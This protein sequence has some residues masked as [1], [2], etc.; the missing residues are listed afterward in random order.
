MSVYHY[1][2]LEHKA[3]CIAQYTTYLLESGRKYVGA[4]P[5]IFFNNKNMLKHGT[6]KNLKLK[7]TL[8]L[9]SLLSLAA[10]S[11]DAIFFCFPI[12][13]RCFITLTHILLYTNIF[14][15][16]KL[17]TKWSKVILDFSRLPAVAT[18]VKISAVCCVCC[19][20]FYFLFV[21]LYCF[22]L[23]AAYEILSF[24]TFVSFFVL[25]AVG[26]GRFKNKE[27]KIYK[28]KIIMFA[29][30]QSLS[31]IRFYSTELFWNFLLHWML[32]Y[33]SCNSISESILNS[34]N[35]MVF[36]AECKIQKKHLD[37]SY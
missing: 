26:K 32:A 34:L 20:F 33:F 23:T 21:A 13:F 15:L 3:V 27:S 37:R 17:K 5:T 19:E 8:T 36:W 12:D 11:Y 30:R 31:M 1:S 22:W 35:F 2:R 29:F 18:I 28:N 7:C 9:V 16:K 14:K 10:L 25:V 4:I 24:Y 6:C